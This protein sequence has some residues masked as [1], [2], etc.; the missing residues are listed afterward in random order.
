MELLKTTG[1]PPWG[2]G[3]S[4]GFLKTEVEYLRDICLL[5]ITDEMNWKLFLNGEVEEGETF[6][7]LKK[8]IDDLIKE[9]DKRRKNFKRERRLVIWTSRYPY[10][11]FILE[12]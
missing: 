5:E 12:C 10:S 7:K 8:V 2:A 4:K 1:N 11:A 9:K 6:T 3:R